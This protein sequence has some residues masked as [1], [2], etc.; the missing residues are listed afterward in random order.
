[1]SVVSGCLSCLPQGPVKHVYRVL[2]CQEEELTQMVSTMSDGWKFEQ[3]H[4]YIYGCCVFVLFVVK[5]PSMGLKR[6]TVCRDSILYQYFFGGS[7]N[8]GIV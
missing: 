2:Q 4:I 8:H 7:Q 5:L 3:V 1:M 6:P